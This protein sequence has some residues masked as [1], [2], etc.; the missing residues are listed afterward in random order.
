MANGKSDYYDVLGVSRSASEREVKDAYRQLALKYH[1]D[2]NP[3]NKEAEE[4]FK[5]INEAY[6][7]LS[8]A[9]KKQMYDQFGHAGVG[10]G[11]GPDFGAGG[12]FSRSGGFGNF[13]DLGDIFGDIFEGVFGRERGSQASS[14][15]GADLRYDLTLSFKEAVFGTEASLNIPRAQTCTRCGGTGAKPGTSRKTCPQCKGA[16]RIRVSQGFFTMNQTCS[17]C[18]GEGTVIESSCPEC[19]GN[20]RVQK[21]TQIKV[22]IPGGVDEGS[23]LRVR[24]EGE[25]GPHGGSAGDLYV[26]VHVQKDPNFTR[27]END[28]VAEKHITF[29]QASLGSEIEVPTLEGSV[30]MKVPPGTQNATVFRIKQKGVP[31]VGGRGRGD[32]LV[33]AIVDIPKNL[34]E[35]EKNLLREFERLRK[36]ERGFWRLFK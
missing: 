5:G 25:A 4:K 22:K 9:R 32:L 20:G 1:P 17:R 36:D 11:G 7:V 10:A 34:T 35:K 12:D 28:L 27:E 24:G 6:E 8:D 15:R 16:G 31:Y 19:R 23:S 18:R 33:R 2:K 21:T 26:V 29:V 30:T 13:G 14:R 3:G